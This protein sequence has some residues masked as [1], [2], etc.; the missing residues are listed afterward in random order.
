LWRQVV[1][2][3]GG[4]GENSRNNRKGEEKKKSDPGSQTQENGEME[5]SR[6]VRTWWVRNQPEKFTTFKGYSTFPGDSTYFQEASRK[7]SLNMGTA[8]GASKGR[9]G[10]LNPRERFAGSVV[11]EMY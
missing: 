7:G 9:R 3:L 4:R 8:Y 5:K 10:V 6:E 11:R 1:G 2:D